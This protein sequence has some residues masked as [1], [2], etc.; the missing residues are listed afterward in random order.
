MSRKS[1]GKREFIRQRDGRA[2]REHM[3]FD[4]DAQEWQMSYDPYVCGQRQCGG[5]CPILG[6]ELDRKKGNVFYDIKI[7][8]QRTDLDGTLFEGQVDT[9]I[10]HGQKL[11]SHT[12]SMDICR[13]CEKQC[14]DRIKRKVEEKYFH[15]LFE[16]EYHGTVFSVE[17]QNIRAERRESRDLMQDLEDIRNGIRVVHV[18]DLEKLEA[19]AKKER[20]KNTHEAAVKRLEKKLLKEGYESLK[21]FSLDRR[22]ADRWLGME[23]I[24]QLEQ[25][26]NE[27]EKERREQPVQISLSDLER[28]EAAGA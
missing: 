18:F 14:Q 17:V 20:R 5:R 11:F 2:C 21:E 1:A 23:R 6:H 22:H 15:Q 26:R 3:T 12:V 19:K 25:Q 24:A 8:R 9:G 28:E 4:R 10:T 13:A 16:A 7:R 27:M